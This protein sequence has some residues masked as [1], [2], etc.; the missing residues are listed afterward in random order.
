MER[1]RIWAVLGAV[2]VVSC[3]LAMAADRG[4]STPEERAT[5]VS[6]TKALESDPM[7]PGARDKRQAMLAWLVAVPDIEAKTC[8][9][10]LSRGRDDKYPYAGEV[11]FQEMFAAGVFAIEHPEKRGDDIAM[12]TAAVESALRAYES[13]LRTR[14]DAKL[15]FFD[16]L[17]AMRD[18]GEL[19]AHVAKVAKKKCK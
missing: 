1:H 3:S 18:R 11:T 2:L 19:A 6:T 13:L 10:L 17:V 14:P 15:A 5:F 12:Y 9:D 8:A 4:P 16:E 7:A